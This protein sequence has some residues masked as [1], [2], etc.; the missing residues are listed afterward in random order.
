MYSICCLILST[1]Y[2]QMSYLHFKRSRIRKSVSA[3]VLVLPFSLAQKHLL[4]TAVLTFKDVWKEKKMT[5]QYLALPFKQSGPSKLLFNISLPSNMAANPKHP[6]QA[7]LKIILVCKDSQLVCQIYH[8]AARGHP[9]WRLPNCLTAACVHQLWQDLAG[10]GLL[11][12][13]TAA[14]LRDNNAP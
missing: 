13:L 3:L 9:I 12:L 11:S 7:V 5:M 4:L 6:S 1:S 10:C 2:F 14:H 8:V